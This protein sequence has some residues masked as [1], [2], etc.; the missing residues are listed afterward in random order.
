VDKTIIQNAE[1]LE[2]IVQ[3]ILFNIEES[4]QKNSKP[5][6]ITRHSKAW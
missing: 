1:T 4:W 2:K 6:K 3:S 5:I